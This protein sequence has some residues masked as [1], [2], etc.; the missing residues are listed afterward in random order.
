MYRQM[1]I[2]DFINEPSGFN[3]NVPCIKFEQLFEKVEN[4]IM[5]CVNCLCQ[6][7][8]NNVEELWHTVMPEEVQEDCFS[9]DE[10]CEYTAGYTH[11]KIQGCERFIMSNYG[12]VRNRKKFKEV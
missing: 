6:Y 1:S 4:P 9:C 3:R 12:A 8:S 7:C 10:C 5:Q 11:Q 2:F